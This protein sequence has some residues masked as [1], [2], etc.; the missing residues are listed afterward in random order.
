MRNVS[1]M[2]QSA[3]FLEYWLASAALV[4]GAWLF[5][6]NQLQRRLNRDSTYRESPITNPDYCREYIEYIPKVGLLVDALIRYGLCWPP[7]VLLHCR[8]SP[9]T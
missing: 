7:R 3:R 8:L 1:K 6:C 9:C 5:Q 4:V 2:A